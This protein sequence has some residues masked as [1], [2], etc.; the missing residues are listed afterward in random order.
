ML[1]KQEI[2]VDVVKI[3]EKNGGELVKSAVLPVV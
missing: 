1:V 3:V 2:L